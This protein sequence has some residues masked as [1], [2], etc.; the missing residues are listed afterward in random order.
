MTRNAPFVAALFIVGACRGA[1]DREQIERYGIG[2]EVTSAEIATRDVDVGPDGAGLPPGRGT[3]AE[4]E[5]IFTNKC[6]SC[7]GPH[8]EGKLPLYPRLIGR[9]PRA[10]TFAF[11]T[12]PSLSRTIGDYWPY[13]TTVFDYVRRAMPFTA[14]G[15]LTNDEVYAVTAYLLAANQVIP[16]TATMDATSLSKVKMPAVGRFVPDTR[17]GGREIK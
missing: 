13:A 9:D 2:H 11:A 7:H 6:A 4:G 1:P 17:R 12:D 8:G 3:A 10:Q 16:S 5:F 14:P 15:T